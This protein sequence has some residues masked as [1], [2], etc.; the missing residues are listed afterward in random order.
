[1]DGHPLTIKLGLTGVKGERDK[2]YVH[3]WLPLVYLFILSEDVCE[4][5]NRK[6]IITEF[7]HEAKP[8]HQCDGIP[9]THFLSSEIV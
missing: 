1:M 3:G 2:G 8:V 5:T 4:Y 6:K 9:Q 7:L